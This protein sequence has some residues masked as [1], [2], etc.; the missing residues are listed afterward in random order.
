MYP[1]CDPAVFKGHQGSSIDQHLEKNREELR[2]R[3]RVGICHIILW[4][5]GNVSGKYSF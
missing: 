2:A 3:E 5:M 1:W 4:F